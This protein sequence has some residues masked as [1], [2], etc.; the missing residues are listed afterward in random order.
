M[1]SKDLVIVEPYIGIGLI[2]SDSDLAASASIFN[3][4]T[5][6]SASAKESSLHLTV[7]L[8]VNLLIL[9]AGLEY[10]RAFDVDRLSAK[11]GFSL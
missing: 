11:V 2:E 4:T 6:T 3:F 1:A 5:N 8:E 10:N 9:K 7:G